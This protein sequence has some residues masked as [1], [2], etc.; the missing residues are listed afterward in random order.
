MIGDYTPLITTQSVCSAGPTMT[1][2][3]FDACANQLHI[4]FYC[5]FGLA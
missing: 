5:P 3:L 2:F 1:Q 4:F